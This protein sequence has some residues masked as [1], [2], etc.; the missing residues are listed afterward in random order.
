IGR[1]IIVAQDGIQVKRAAVAGVI[2]IDIKRIARRAGGAAAGERCTLQM[3]LLV[4]ECT[5]LTRSARYDPPVSE[6]L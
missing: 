5:A 1:R 4:S 2:A 3:E 6:K